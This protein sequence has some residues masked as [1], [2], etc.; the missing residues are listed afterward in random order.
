MDFLKYQ[1]LEALSVIWHTNNHA[2]H[3]SCAAAQQQQDDLS[4]AR[5]Q[6]PISE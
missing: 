6:L 4:K 2:A 1:V 3:L 5:A